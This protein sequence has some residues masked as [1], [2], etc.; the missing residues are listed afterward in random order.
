MSLISIHQSFPFKT[1][2]LIFKYFIC[3]CIWRI[4]SSLPS[5]SHFNILAMAKTGTTPS[6]SQCLSTSLSVSLIVYLS[7]TV[8]V[9]LPVSRCLASVCNPL[10][11]LC[12]IAHT[13]MHTH[14]YTL[15]HTDTHTLYVSVSVSF[16]RFSSTR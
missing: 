7:L 2:H 14:A 4:V 3:F 16:C 12:F 10:L 15:T 6:L 9:S 11:F 1:A 5:P 8:S 13:R